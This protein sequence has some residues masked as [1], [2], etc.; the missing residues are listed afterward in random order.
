MCKDLNYDLRKRDINNRDIQLQSIM[1]KAQSELPTL[2]AVSDSKSLY[3]KL[4]V[5]QFTNA[6]KRAA[7]EVAVIRDSLKSLGAA[8]RWVPHELNV[9]DCLTKKKG[10]SAPLLELLRTG[11]YQL[12]IE[13]QELIRRKEERE[14]TGKRNARPKRMTLDP[15]GNRASS[16]PF[17]KKFNACLLYTSP[18]PRDS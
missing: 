7:L 4:V 8:T 6:E 16:K 13:E 12:V 18:S 15:R 14:R 5:E 1:S 2:L 9:S 10:N 11:K 3:D 17:F